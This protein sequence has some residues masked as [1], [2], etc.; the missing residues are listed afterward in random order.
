MK[1]RIELLTTF[2]KNTK[3]VKTTLCSRCN[4]EGVTGYL[5]VD[6]GVCFKCEGKGVVSGKWLAL[7]NKL[8]T[9][10]SRLNEMEEEKTT[11]ITNQTF[12]NERSK[13]R[14]VNRISKKHNEQLEHFENILSNAEIKSG[15]IM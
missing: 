8:E 7:V 13:E 5:H 15:F 6:N 2:I 10:V 11:F 14:A 4:G 3:E 9:I 12:R 1:A